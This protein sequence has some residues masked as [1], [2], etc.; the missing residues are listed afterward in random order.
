MA[1]YEIDFTKTYMTTCNVE[2][3]SPGEA[4]KEFYK[5][6]YQNTLENEMVLH[7]YCPTIVSVTNNK[8]EEIEFITVD[9]VPEGGIAYNEDMEMFDVNNH[10]LSLSEVVDKFNWDEK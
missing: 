1:K 5:K 6:W 2:A 10:Y 7:D 3:D 9:P 4:M 8:T